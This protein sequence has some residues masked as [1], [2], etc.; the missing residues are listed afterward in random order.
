VQTPVV[1]ALTNDNGVTGIGPTNGGSDVDITG[2]NFGP[3]DALFNPVTAEYYSTS[4]PQLSYTARDC[5]VVSQSRIT[6]KTAP[7][8]FGVGLRF[9]PPFSPPPLRLAERC[10]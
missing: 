2:F 8:E 5:V 7:G 9:A 10:I 1:T 6:C 4:W 3:A